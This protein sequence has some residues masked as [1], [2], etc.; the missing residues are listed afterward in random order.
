MKKS[1]S[2]VLFTGLV[3]FPAAAAHKHRSWLDRANADPKTAERHNPCAGDGDAVQAG[4]K[5][6]HRY[7]SSCHGANATGLGR[8]PA[9]HSPTVKSASPGALYWLLRNGS[10][11]RG[12]PSWSYLPPAQRWQ[13]VTWMKTLEF[14]VEK[15]P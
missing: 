10:L 5:L 1:L 13:L 7:C 14:P 2:M 8:S 15:K 3:L 9:L 6:Y 12:M 4:N 11:K